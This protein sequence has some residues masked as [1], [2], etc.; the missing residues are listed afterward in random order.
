MLDKS[1]NSLRG[2]LDY[3]TPTLGEAVATHP[4][5]SLGG[6]GHALRYSSCG[7]ATALLQRHLEREYGIAT[8]RLRNASIL[9]VPKRPSSS[10]AYDHVVLHEPHHDL[11][12]DPT[13]SQ[14]MS[15]FGLT[16][17]RASVMSSELRDQLYP[18]AQIALFPATDYR[19][20]SSSIIAYAAATETERVESVGPIGISKNTR[21]PAGLSEETIN[22]V[23]A[24]IWNIDRYEPYIYPK[25]AARTAEFVRAEN[26]LKTSSTQEEV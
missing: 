19:E 18:K 9:T 5:Y 25:T 16:A 23:V 8:H 4:D 2:L 12:I 20:F 7:F 6:S 11:V 17:I 14:F 1:F 21:L 22:H 3:V 10:G 26:H 13:Y 24:E 15:L